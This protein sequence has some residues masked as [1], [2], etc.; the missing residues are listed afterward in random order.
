MCSGER[1]GEG[2]SLSG[3]RCGFE[4]GSD[5][6]P[7]ANAAGSFGLIGGPGRTEGAAGRVQDVSPTVVFI[8]RIKRPWGAGAGQGVG[9]DTDVDDDYASGS[10]SH[11]GGATDTAKCSF[12]LIVD[13]GGDI[14]RGRGSAADVVDIGVIEVAIRRGGE[15]DG[16]DTGSGI[17]GVEDKAFTAVAAGSMLTRGN[18]CIALVVGDMGKI[19]AGATNVGNDEEITFSSA[20]RL[21]D[22]GLTIEDKKSDAV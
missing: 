5:A 9:F 15:G 18:V 1:A 8:L 3:C 22:S 19:I 14:E 12:V 10:G 17:G 13:G 21:R 11:N 20:N 2:I 6:A 4:G 7:E 16:G